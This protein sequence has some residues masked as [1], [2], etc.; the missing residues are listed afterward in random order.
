MDS[1][2]EVFSLKINA[3]EASISK[4]VSPGNSELA[5]VGACHR[6]SYLI[7]YYYLLSSGMSV[8]SDDS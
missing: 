3:E 1:V 4:F 8:H 7:L 6:S 2:D 5:Y